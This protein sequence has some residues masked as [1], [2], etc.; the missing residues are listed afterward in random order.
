[1]RIFFYKIHGNF[2]LKRLSGNKKQS[3]FSKKA[4]GKMKTAVT[5]TQIIFLNLGFRHT[6]N[7]GVLRFLEET[8]SLINK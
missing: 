6:I 3:L 8:Y 2:I 4:Q 5:I 7:P 1:M